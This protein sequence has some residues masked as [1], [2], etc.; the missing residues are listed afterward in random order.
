MYSHPSELHYF[1][2]DFTLSLG[3]PV[4]CIMLNSKKTTLDTNRG[5]LRCLASGEL[6]EELVVASKKWLRNSIS[7]DLVV[8]DFSEA[9]HIF[10]LGISIEGNHG[11]EQR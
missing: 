9:M 5:G 11:N 10:N 3:N 6:V 2:C 4:L 1:N 8:G 7:I